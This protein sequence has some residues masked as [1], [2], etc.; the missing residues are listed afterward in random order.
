MPKSKV[1][2]HPDLPVDF[3]PVRCHFK[4]RIAWEAGIPE[5][6]LG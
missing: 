3:E 5:W 4:N 1:R 6:I 2:D